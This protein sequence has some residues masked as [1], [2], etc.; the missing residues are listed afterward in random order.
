[1]SLRDFFSGGGWLRSRAMSDQPEIND[2]GLISQEQEEEHTELDEPASQEN[3]PEESMS[4]EQEPQG[5]EVVVKTI[6][7]IDKHPG[8]AGLEK[9][10]DG[11]NNLVQQLQGINEN[12][13]RQASHHEELMSRIEQL[14]QLL[15][16]LPAVVDNQKHSTEMLLDQLKAN[17]AKDQQFME[18]VEK[19]PTETGKQTDALVNINHQLAAAAD[20][21]VQMAENFN[22]FNQTLEKL[23]ESTLG[24]TDSIM[25]MSKTFAASDRY[26]KYI[27]SRQN[28]RFLWVLVS[29]ISVCVIVVLILT[30]IIIYLGR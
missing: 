22:K 20:T 6:E 2:E 25:Q 1:M 9:L 21:D 8:T 10:Q 4:G 30:G 27:I 24:Q 7:P 11:L 3:E 15:E 23:D 18:T 17:A 19:I 14:P 12:L 26:L 16:S 29:A 5:N 13:N 28:K